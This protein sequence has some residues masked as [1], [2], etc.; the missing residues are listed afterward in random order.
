MRDKFIRWFTGAQPLVVGAW[1][2]RAGV[3]LARARPMDNFQTVMEVVYEP[4]GLDF[5]NQ[6]DMGLLNRGETVNALRCAAERLGGLEF[7]LAL[8]IPSGD[9]FIKNIEI[10]AGM[11]TK[12]IEQISLVEA[13]S[14]LPV[15]PEEICADFLKNNDGR[16]VNT[17]RIDIAFCKRALID[18][19]G[20]VAEDAGVV[21]SVVDRDIQAVHDATLWCAKDQGSLK[22]VE[23]PLGLLIEGEEKT[24]IVS[25]S[26][27]DHVSYVFK[28]ADDDSSNLGLTADSVSKEL[29]AYCRR[30]GLDFENCRPLKQLFL[31]V[32]ADSSAVAASTIENLSHETLEIHPRTC[33][34]IEGGITPVY[35]LMVAMGMALRKAA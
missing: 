33:V 32:D 34:K 27:L 30:A 12:Q 25:R 22:S 7:T 2:G 6:T 21:L 28:S 8:G 9:I 19:L 5:V 29:Q 13:V 4:C 1:W 35:G 23:Y 20:I 15:P 24:F 10:P 17:E 14:N 31:V 16:S 3:C 11:T 18:D 26:A